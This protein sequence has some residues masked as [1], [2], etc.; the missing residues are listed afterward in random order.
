MVL[1]DDFEGICWDIL[2]RNPLSSAD[3]VF[4]ELLVEEIRLKSHSILIPDKGVLSTPSSAFAAP[5]HKGKLQVIQKIFKSPSSNV[6]V[7][8]PTTVG[9]GSDCAYPSE[10][11]SQIYDIVE[12]LQKLLTT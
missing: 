1:R 11:T 12:Q 10:T 8:A 6:V 3:S 7:A 5:F 4:N 2:H 9:S